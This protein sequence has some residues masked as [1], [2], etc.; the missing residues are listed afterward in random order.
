[1]AVGEHSGH[2]AGGELLFRL[3]TTTAISINNLLSYSA[4]FVKP[5]LKL[6][7]AKKTMMAIRTAVSDRKRYLIIF[8]SHWFVPGVFNQNDVLPLFCYPVKAS[9]KK[10]Q[11]LSLSDF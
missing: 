10:M 7:L 6:A 1:M 2:C 11:I 3:P 9:F 8:L 4:L 5:K